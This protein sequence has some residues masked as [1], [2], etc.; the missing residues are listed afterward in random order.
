[1]NAIKLLKQQHREVAALWKKFDKADDEA[2][3][4]QLFEEIADRL[5][6]HASIEE[7]Y[8]YPTVRARQTEQQLQEAYDEHLEVKK[9]ILDAMDG[10]DRPG[11]DAIVAALMGAVE[12]HVR[13]EEHELFPAVEKLF[14]DKE[15]DSLGKTMQQEAEALKQAGD[16][17]FMVRATIEQPVA[18]M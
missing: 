5:A 13:E 2:D 16:P 1:M 3:K 12:H 18:P 7:R 17:R 4:E 6:V 10:L 14:N 9:L 11:F 15:L 8:F